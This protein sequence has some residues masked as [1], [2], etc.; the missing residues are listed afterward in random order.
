[1]QQAPIRRPD[2]HQRVVAGLGEIHLRR[3]AARRAPIVRRGME[4][5]RNVIRRQPMPPEFL[6]K[7][8]RMRRDRLL[9]HVEI[10]HPAGQRARQRAPFRVGATASRSMQ[11]VPRISWIMRSPTTVSVCRASLGSSDATSAAVWHPKA[12][13]LAWLARP[14]PQISSRGKQ[15]QPLLPRLLARQVADTAKLRRALGDVIRASL[16]S[17]SVRSRRRSARPSKS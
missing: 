11:G 5:H 1:M 7:T 14:M 15:R 16:A 3:D 4:K 9:H 10:I 13:S 2:Q 6:A 17:L 12:A 8:Y